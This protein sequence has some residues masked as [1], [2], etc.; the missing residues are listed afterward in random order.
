MVALVVAVWVEQP[1]PQ[2]L[3]LL[4]KVFLAAAVSIYRTMAAAA[5]VALEV[6]V[7]LLLL[8]QLVMVMVLLVALDFVQPSMDSVFYMLVAAAAVVTLRVVLVLLA[9]TLAMV[10]VMGL[11][12]QML[13]PTMV[14]A[15]VAMEIHLPLVMAVLAS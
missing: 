15:G 13:L 9:L 11:L 14:V 1:T 8:P 10:E 6:Q 7:A 4:D 3:E 2:E 5:E 12:A